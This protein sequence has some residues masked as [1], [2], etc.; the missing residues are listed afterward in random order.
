MNS[1]I[2]L[3]IVLLAAGVGKRMQSPLPKVLHEVN[4]VPMINRLI[5]ECLK[6]N[7]KN[8][9]IV[10]GFS[11]RI[12]IDTVLNTFHDNKTL[13][14][15][16]QEVPLGTGDAVKS[17]LLLLDNNNEDD[18]LLVLNGDNALL[19]YDTLKD[20][21]HQYLEQQTSL[22]LCC[23]D[24]EDPTGSGRI[25]KNSEGEFEKIVEEKDCDPETKLI[26]T[27]N[28]GIY[29]GKVSIFNKYV[30]KIESNNAQSEFYLTD[31]VQIYKYHEEKSPELIKLSDDK[32]FEIFNI[33]TKE[34]LDY[35]NNVLK[36]NNR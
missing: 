30:P 11:S 24:Q 21:Y 13:K 35:V 20:V 1:K 33:N 29:I 16:L 15:C 27:I 28:V 3:N 17:A 22:Q 36:S 23:I 26:K 2:M 18:D 14:F 32:Q 25:I 10:V 31:I 34:Q 7:P 5:S 4:G 12:V 6:L 19:T 9:I 8:I